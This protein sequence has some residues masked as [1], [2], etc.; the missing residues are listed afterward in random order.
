MEGL[1]L[2]VIALAVVVV[3]L[4]LITHRRAPAKPERIVVEPLGWLIDHW[5]F[6]RS[7]GQTAKVAQML[8]LFR[9]AG[10]HTDRGVSA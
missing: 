6:A 4:A 2:F 10:L 3:F 8:E 7:F 1:V 9:A 5:V